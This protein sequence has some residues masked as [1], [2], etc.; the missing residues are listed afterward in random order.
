MGMRRA[1]GAEQIRL[2]AQLDYIQQK[3]FGNG[4]DS[5]AARLSRME[6]MLYRLSHE[7]GVISGKV[8]IIAAAVSAVIGL[9]MR[10]GAR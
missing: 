4:A 3:L 1:D 7:Q 9:V 2:R 10:F 6:D 8:A 5:I